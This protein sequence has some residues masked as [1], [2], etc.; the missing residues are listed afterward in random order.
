MCR[1]GVEDIVMPIAT[2]IARDIGRKNEY[3]AHN[4]PHISR[5]VRAVVPRVWEE[6]VQSIR[7]SVA[8]LPTS[9]LIWLCGVG[10]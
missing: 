4:H 8:S 1:S 7:D 2:K 3:T 6:W 9:A 10:C 5:L